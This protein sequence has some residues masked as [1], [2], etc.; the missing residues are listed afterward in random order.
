M[1]KKF[2]PDLI[3]IR[4]NPF[5]SSKSTAITDG[6]F[7]KDIVG[8]SDVFI[9]LTLESVNVGL[10]ISLSKK[11]QDIEDSK[12]PQNILVLGEYG[13]GKSF[14]LKKIQD[15]IYTKHNGAIVSYSI[16]GNASVLREETD[17]FNKKI[18]SDIES[19]FNALDPTLYINKDTIDQKYSLT[20]DAI[21]KTF[22]QFLNSYDNAFQELGITVYIFIDEL[23]KIVTS[24][25]SESIIKIFLEDLKLI[26]DTCGKSISLII[27]GTQNCLVKMNNLSVDY[28]QRFD[29]VE[30]SYL[31]RQE[32]FDYIS[33]KCSSKVDYVGYH[34]FD[35]ESK[36]L[37]YSLTG[38]NIRKIE[39]LSRELWFYSSRNK[40]KITRQEFTKFMQIR[41][42]ETIKNILG[43][44]A[45]NHQISIVIELY[46]KKG[47]IGITTLSKRLSK[48]KF[49]EIKDLFEQGTVLTVI[50]K[51]YQLSESVNE[52]I[53][54]ALLD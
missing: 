50:G 4:N 49:K 10:I 44:T 46:L 28:S 42:F 32:T 11:L 8:I 35:N 19:L 27:A 31:T 38:G 23:D 41:L 30:S 20:T 22:H 37:I 2:F 25:A 21:G 9:P 34:P 26:A 17:Y 33:K 15:E 39:V 53:D 40:V 29:V 24:D 14:S 51:S 3:E 7:M 5:S 52:L 43:K 1:L 6:I 45:S 18:M 12:K 54:S 36:N 47:R 13:Q 16:G 48:S